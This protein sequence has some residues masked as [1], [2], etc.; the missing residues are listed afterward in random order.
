M[1]EFSPKEIALQNGMSG[2]PLERFYTRG[3]AG[4]AAGSASVVPDQTDGLLG[5]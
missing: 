4:V 1:N 5:H 2:E 3:R